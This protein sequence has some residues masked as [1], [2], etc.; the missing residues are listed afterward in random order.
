MRLGEMSLHQI[1]SN[2]P[3]E[4]ENYIIFKTMLW[5]V[6][7]KSLYMRMLYV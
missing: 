1:I 2:T 6:E 7:T 5:F 4:C 3:R